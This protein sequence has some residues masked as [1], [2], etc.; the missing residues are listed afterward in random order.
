MQQNQPVATTAQAAKELASTAK[1]FD[2]RS[3]SFDWNSVRSAL[4][5]LIASGEVFMTKRP[6][7]IV[8]LDADND[9][10]MATF[11]FQGNPRTYYAHL[12]SIDLPQSRDDE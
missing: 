5:P 10:Y 1:Y 6:S 12:V 7:K 11:N 4:A 8:V 9:N 2:Q 3:E